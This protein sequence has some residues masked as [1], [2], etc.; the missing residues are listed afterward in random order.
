M[1]DEHADHFHAYHQLERAGN[2]GLADEIR[3][4]MRVMGE[5]DG[6]LAIRLVQT[7]ELPGFSGTLLPGRRRDR[8]P[9]ITDSAQ[10]PAWATVVLSLT[11]TDIPG[12]YTTSGMSSEPF[13]EDLPA[14]EGESLDTDGL[15]DYFEGLGLQGS[16][17]SIDGLVV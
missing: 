15:L 17:H 7:S 10:L 5:I 6:H 2:H 11:R 9:N 16:K 3:E 12:S 13:S 4:R 14:Y 1:L 8:D